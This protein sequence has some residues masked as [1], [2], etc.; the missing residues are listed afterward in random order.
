[1]TR[2]LLLTSVVALLLAACAPTVLG[3]R[4]NPVD[5]RRDRTAVVQPGGTVYVRISFP[6]GAFGLARD[7]FA[8]AF[9]VPLGAGGR[10]ARVTSSFELL[11]VAAP[12]GWRWTLDDVWSESRAGQAPALVVTMR[13]DVPR[14]A[15]LGGQAVGATLLARPSGGREPVTLVVQVVPR[16]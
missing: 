11:D 10:G 3:S 2:A 9:A 12:A 6:T 5:L 16:P 7:A 13:I 4:G 15:R 14:D 8:D 1:M